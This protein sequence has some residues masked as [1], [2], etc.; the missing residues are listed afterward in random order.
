MVFSSALRMLSPK[1]FLGNYKVFGSPGVTE[2]TYRSVWIKALT[3]AVKYLIDNGYYKTILTNWSVTEGA[4]AST[5]VALNNNNSIGA[6]CVPS[7]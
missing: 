3:D 7:Y 6:S 2:Y 1:A 4:I 5:D